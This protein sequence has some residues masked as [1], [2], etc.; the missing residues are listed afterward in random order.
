MAQARPPSKGGFTPVHA[1]MIGFV[2][3]W[4]TSTVLLVWLYTDQEGL[5]ST[6]EDLRTRN[7]QV[8]RNRNDTERQRAETAVLA[9]GEEAADVEEVRAKITALLDQIVSERYV[10]DTSP[11]E[12]AALLPAAIALY[13]N[14]TGENEL[15]LA[16]EDRARAAEDELQQ[17]ID[18][19]EQLKTDFDESTQALKTR[20]DEIESRRA[21][22]AANRDQEVD[23]FERKMDENRQQYSR[24]IQD[25]RT[26]LSKER[27]RRETLETRYATLQD[28]VGELQIKPGEL[29]T[30]R[31]ADGQVVLAIPGDDVVYIDLG[32]R[33]QLTTG[34]QFAVY[35]GSGIPPDGRAKARIEVTRV[36]AGTA[37]CEV[38]K[39]GRGEVI[40]EGDIVSNPVYDRDK[41]LRFV[42]VG[43][44]DLNRDGRDDPHGADQV[45]SIIQDWGGHVLDRI[46]SRADFIVAGYAPK[47][48]V[49]VSGDAARRDP[50][51]MERE[52]LY[53]QHLQS[54]ESAVASANELSIPILTQDVFL[55]F[56]GY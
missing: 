33:H 43:E 11:F 14:L 8:T 40:L 30:A 51:A 55:K 35:P 32:S 31:T 22:Y 50:G 46:S 19:H 53:E 9:V 17:L 42:V 12:T 37:E 5:K 45:K 10:A 47:A 20:V 21:S 56:L 26:A 23:D 52:R 16:A 36:H 39:L 6:A 18:T 13:E 41:P 15:R 1:W 27:D 4:L 49:T 7:D 29:L 48:P 2:F 3:L 24:D 28:K 38:V 44:F 25:Q 34:L 54:Y